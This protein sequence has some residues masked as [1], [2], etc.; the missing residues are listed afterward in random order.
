MSYFKKF[1]DL[2]GGI[3]AA[4]AAVFVI[5]R[6]M[7]YNPSKIEEGTSKLRMFFSDDNSK[8]Y[9]PYLILIA[10]I[11]LAVFFGRVLKRFSSV[12]FIAS[13]LSLSQ[14]LSMLREQKLY[15]HKGFYL[16]VCIVLICGNI[17]ELVFRDKEDG[18]K[19]TFYA[20]GA[21]GV[22]SVAISFVSLKL[23]AM[24]ADFSER[25]LDSSTILG[26]EEAILSNRLELAGIE[27]IQIVSEK[28]RGVLIF[29]A[30]SLLVGVVVSFILRGAYFIDIVL[31]AVPFVYTFFALHGEWLPT[32]TMLVLVPIWVYFICRATLFVTGVGIGKTVD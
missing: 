4:F 11:V 13:V 2:I 30:V 31:A 19:R 28:E 7:E 24:A 6:Y 25:F 14:V 26:E 32:A 21:L 20:T 1:T 10:L 17:Y 18:G 15:E 8:E 12:G 3:G 22:F 27:L 9:R 16:F 5:G 23:S 29:M